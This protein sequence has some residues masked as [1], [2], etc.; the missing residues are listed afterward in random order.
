HCGEAS[1][2]PVGVSWDPHLGAT[3]MAVSMPQMWNADWVKFN[4]EQRFTADADR[5]LA[6]YVDRTFWDGLTGL[7]ATSAPEVLAVETRGSVAVVRLHYRLSVELPSEAARFIDTSNVS[8]V[9]ETT[10][11][12]DDRSAKVTFQPDQAARL[13]QASATTRLLPLDQSSSAQGSSVDGSVRMIDGEIK[14]RIPLLGSRVE[15]AII[16]GIGEHL[17]EEAAEIQRHL[18]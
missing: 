18:D 8:W 17:V 12:L 3:N 4:F 10:W 11:N 15:R 2:A 5:V 14:V 13:I 1:K 7:S 9:Q 6:V 16:G